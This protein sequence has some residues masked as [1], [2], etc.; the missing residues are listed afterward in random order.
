MTIEILVIAKLFA[1]S[2]VINKVFVSRL[3]TSFFYFPDVYN[4]DILNHIFKA[5]IFTITFSLINI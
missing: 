3:D 2:K 4:F 5:L 1:N